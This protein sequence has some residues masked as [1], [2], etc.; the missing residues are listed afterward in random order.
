MESKK[1]LHIFLHV[2]KRDKDFFS[3]VKKILLD[4]H[5]VNLKDIYLTSNQY[6]LVDTAEYS[7]N[8][9]I[10]STSELKILRR[11]FT[12]LGIYKY[13]FNKIEKNIGKTKPKKVILYLADEGVWGEVIKIFEKKIIEKYK[14]KVELIN[15]QHGFF[16]LIPTSYLNLRKLLNKVSLLIT[17]YP[18]IGYGFGGSTLSSYFVYGE[19]ERKY[20][21]KKSPHSSVFVSPYICK[22]E[23]IKKVE[24]VQVAIGKNET[25]I[26]SNILFAAQINDINPDA[27]YNEEEIT[28]K[29]SPLFENLYNKG[30]NIY[31]RLHPAIQNKD[32]Y[33]ALLKKY[34][35]FDK[36]IISNESS[37]NEDLAKSCIVL[38]LQSTTLYDG[39]V[40]NRMPVIVRGLTKA[41]D[42]TVPHENIKLDENL[43]RQIDDIYSKLNLYFNLNIT[44]KVE[45]EVEKHIK[46]LIT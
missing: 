10:K 45:V 9:F 20:I 32:F 43:D 44:K 26:R 11:I 29:I 7:K 6:E 37:L 13:L 14:I 12:Y 1:T 24:E 46:K 34:N 19:M 41:F 25:E 15:I 28:K 2:V 3:G 18:L 27:L 35:I 8:I 23:L 21:Q 36:V 39:Y 4:F 17:G 33:Y 5:Q 16:T 40:L 31:Y 30:F 22:Y 42:F 38:S